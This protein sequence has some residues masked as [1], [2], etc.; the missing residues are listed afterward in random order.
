MKQLETE[1]LILRAFTAEDF[2][3]VHAYASV[4][5]NVIYMPFGPNS[6][7]DTRTFLAQCVAWSLE[8]PCTHYE[9]AVVNKQTGLVIGGC[10][11]VLSPAGKEG[12]IGWILHRD[13]WRQGYGAELGRALLCLAFDELA[14]HRVYAV[15]DAENR[16][17]FGLMEKLGMRREACFLEARQANKRSN[18]AYGDELRYALLHSEWEAQREMAY[19]NALPCV[20]DDFLPLPL[21]EDGPL[22]LVCTNKV[23]ADPSRSYVPAYEFAVCM[24]SERIGMLRLRI[25]YTDGL[26]YGGQI[27]YEIDEAFRGHGYAAAACRLVLPL[28]KAHGMTKLL[29]SNER[30]NLAS[31]RVC[32]KLGA[33]HVR[34]ARL[35]EWTDLYR[36]E[37][38]RWTNIYELTL[39]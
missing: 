21:L 1:R 18:E 6:E 2:E 4:L 39:P 11:L 3:A 28:A 37:G 14:L 23:P 16:A 13:F 30:D 5:E 35:P 36:E 19:Y 38:M 32:E 8:E 9:F 15:C 24:G 27:G 29:V 7:Q 33:K 10:D 26:Y 31:R 17:S 22:R 25:G 20:F 12:E 34:L